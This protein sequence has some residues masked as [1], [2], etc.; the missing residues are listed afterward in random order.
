MNEHISKYQIIVIGAGSGGLVVAIGAAKAGKKVLL[1]EKGTYGG[2]CTNFGCI[3]SKTLI[4]SAKLAHTIQRAKD[5]GLDGVSPFTNVKGAFERMKSIVSFVRAQEEPQALKEKGVETITGIASFQDAHHIQIKT[6]DS[7]Q[8]L[9]YGEN[10]VIATGSSPNVPNITGLLE[11][12]Y[13]TNETIFDLNDAPKR[14][15][16][17]GGGPIGCEMA[18][19]FSRLGSKVY[20][21]HRHLELLNKEEQEAQKLIAETFQKEGIE[22]FLGFETQSI[23]Y[24]KPEFKLLIKSSIEQKEIVSDALLIAVGRKPNIDALCL[25]KAGVNF[26]EKGIKVDKY[27]RTSQKH[28]WAIGDVVCDGPKFTHAAENQARKVL[29][30]LLLPFKKRQNDQ[31]MPRV[32][33]TDPEVAGFGLSEKQAVKLYNQKIKVYHIPFSENDRAITAGRTD[34]FVKITTK[35]ISGQILG[36]TIV[37]ARAGEMLLELSLAAKKKIPLYK[38]SSLIHPYPIYNSAIRNAAD[39]WLTQT[40]LPWV[41]HLFHEIKWKRFIPILIL[42][43]LMILAYLTEIYKYF[44]LE[45]LQEQQFALK[46]FVKTH[47]ILSPL[48]FIL[49]YTISTGLS[50]PGA[51]TL[52][53]I[54]GFLFPL[55]LSTLYVII[56]ATLGAIIIFLASRTALGEILRRKAGSLLKKLE[57]GFQ[58]N[59]WSY[60]LFLRLIPIFPFWLVNIAAA[61]FQVR[62]LTFLWTTFIGIIPGSYLY[63]QAGAGI[64][65]IL[66]SKE[67]LSFSAIFNIQLIISLIGIGIL[68]LAA[69]ITKKF[70]LKKIKK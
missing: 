56:G 20:Q 21:I 39:L 11:T 59:A 52:S 27:G 70:I 66:E 35:K 10:I 50:L 22:L 13:L 58:K 29:V 60:L 62:F 34:G 1:I 63:T 67:P 68:M 69:F 5:F 57:K 23:T 47:Y 64:E 42:L 55:P 26:S 32:T 12:P 40:F 53:L 48:I 15:C 8:K 25:N 46:K 17:I 18:Q 36:A 16:I 38:L 6:N 14:L 4:A 49:I 54:G 2:D 37:G 30:S 44:S 9:V 7:S 19:T 24:S 28:I 3:P 41:K 51:A 45:T 31:A 43:I 65:N 61:F 33:F